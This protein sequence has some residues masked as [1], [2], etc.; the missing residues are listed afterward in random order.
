MTPEEVAK[1]KKKMDVMFNQNIKKPSD[2]D[3]QYDKRVN[4]EAVRASEWDEDD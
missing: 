3:Y 4:F 2:P 1:H